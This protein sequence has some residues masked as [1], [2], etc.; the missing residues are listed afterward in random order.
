M[1]VSSVGAARAAR[2]P[3]ARGASLFDRCLRLGIL[4]CSSAL[5][6]GLCNAFI[7]RPSPSSAAL[8][9]VHS[10]GRGAFVRARVD[11]SPQAQAVVAASVAVDA[12]SLSDL[13]AEAKRLTPEIRAE[14]MCQ[15]LEF[16]SKYRDQFVVVKYGGHAMTDDALKRGFCRDVAAL[17]QAGV[18]VVVV[19]GG[20]PQISETL[21]KLGIE[22]K[23]VEGLRI[24]DADTLRVTE[25]VLCGA[26]N[27][28]LVSDIKA[29]GAR[30]VGLSGRD[31]HFLIAEQLTKTVVGDDGNQQ[32]IDLG[33]VGT[34]KRVDS[35][36]LRSLCKS[37]YV[38][39]V[40][41][42]GV[43]EKSETFNINADT[44]A[45]A[46]AAELKAA[47]FLLLTDVPGVLDGERC[48]IDDI[49]VSELDGLIGGG[50]ISGGMIPKVRTA[51]DAVEKGVGGVAILDGRVPH[52]VL[53]EL[54]TKSGIG[55]LIH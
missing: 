40:A 41:P 22:S 49:H 52:A 39:V 4:L 35:S 37:H 31:D 24:T 27:K 1:E 5:R 8:R 20:G 17:R 45:G 6:T 43:G 9:G 34:P 3:N 33:F 16:S 18:N 12:P 28:G 10:S 51:Q 53:M 54:C 47:R 36:L 13:E 7:V 38:P 11:S 50:T 44:A 14:V 48:L 25:M 19:H 2:R 30:S 23:R 15:F 29:A 26:V 42:I 21:T 32:E 55:T 46:I